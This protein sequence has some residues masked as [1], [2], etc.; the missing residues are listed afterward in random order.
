MEPSLFNVYRCL[1]FDSVTGCS[2]FNSKFHDINV[3]LKTFVIHSDK[4][5]LKLHQVIFWN[6]FKGLR[7]KLCMLTCYGKIYRYLNLKCSMMIILP[8]IVPR[9]GISS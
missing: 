4:R 6:G 8:C 5:S 2:F 1:V 9:H 7:L 3:P